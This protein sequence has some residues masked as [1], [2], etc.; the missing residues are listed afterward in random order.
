MD[1]PH[2]CDDGHFGCFRLLAIM[3]NSAVNTVV[4]VSIWV[5]A[6][7]FWRGLYPEV[8]LLGHVVILTLIFEELLY[9]F[10]EWLNAQGS[11]FSISL[12]VSEF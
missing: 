9:C 10:T 1:G 4:Q 6:F 11:S 8:E 7:N 5:P 12:P 2:L 3:N